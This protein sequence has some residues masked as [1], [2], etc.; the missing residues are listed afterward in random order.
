MA[1]VNRLDGGGYQAAARRFAIMKLCKL[2]LCCVAVIAVFYGLFVEMFD[3]VVL[4]RVVAAGR[5]R[6]LHSTA[7]RQ[8]SPS[9]RHP[10]A[11]RVP[12]LWLAEA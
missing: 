4:V 8:T 3:G 2:W 12:L 1:T 6:L 9:R 7:A 5:W 10:L 11:A